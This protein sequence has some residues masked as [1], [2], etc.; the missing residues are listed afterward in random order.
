MLAS[1]G[2]AAR[3]NGNATGNEKEGLEGRRS[4]R[5]FSQRVAKDSKGQATRAPEPTTQPA[6]E[7][8]FGPSKSCRK[9][10]ARYRYAPERADTAVA[11]DNQARR[12]A[13]R[14]EQRDRERDAGARRPEAARLRHSSACLKRHST[15]RRTQGCRFPPCSKVQ[16]GV[17]LA[18]AVADSSTLAP[19]LC[20]L[21]GD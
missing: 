18:R 6:F 14:P 4:T 15:S 1:E 3:T 21:A 9:G 2:R 10:Y 16:A 20:R 5:A 11:A 8:L 17:P 19:C 13:T 12:A 7:G